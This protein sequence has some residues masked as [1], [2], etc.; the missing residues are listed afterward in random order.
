MWATLAFAV[1]VSTSTVPAQG[2]PLKLSNPR[3]TYGFLGAPRA[4]NA[5]LPGDVY[6][7]TF[8]IENL[9]MKEDGEVTYKMG[10]ELINDKGKVLFGEEPQEKKA[11]NSLGGKSLPAF[12]ATEVGTNTP[13][14]KYTVKVTVIDPAAKGA[15]GTQNLESKFE[16]L[17]PG[18]GVVRL[19]TVYLAAPVTAPPVLVP[20][21]SILVNCSVVGF[22]RAKAGDKQPNIGLQM[23]VIDDAT[24]LPVLAKPLL[25]EIKQ[26]VPEELNA[27]PISMPLDLNRTGKFTIELQVTDRVNTTAK[28]VVVKL[29]IHV[30]DK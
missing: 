24:G 4:E 27:I 22:E 14:G 25:D 12:A 1:A 13:P 5:V 15:A 11:R 16:V 29:P 6:F 21:Q 18:F 20:G 30:V 8:D 26:K 9:T 19:N 17:P 28:P 23:R 10:L 3:A 2:G 7:I